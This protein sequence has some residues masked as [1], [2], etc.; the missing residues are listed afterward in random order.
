MTERSTNLC[1]GAKDIEK[2]YN[3]VNSVKDFFSLNEC[4]F[5]FDYKQFNL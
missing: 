3:L 4:N 1:L 5:I 2:V